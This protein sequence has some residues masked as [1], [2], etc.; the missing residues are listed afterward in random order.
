MAAEDAWGNEPVETQRANALA[1]FH[2][3]IFS[4]Y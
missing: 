1:Y 4:D 2:L 3:E